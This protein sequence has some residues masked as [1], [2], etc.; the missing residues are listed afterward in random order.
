MLTG[1]PR[2]YT[3]LDFCFTPEYYHSMLVHHVSAHF[4][5]I[6]L[7]KRSH[8]ITW[9]GA[10]RPL[11]DY[12][13]Y[14]VVC[15]AP[16][17]SKLIRISKTPVV[18]ARLKYTHNGLLAWLWTLEPCFHCMEW[19]GSTWLDSFLVPG[20]FAISFSTADITPSTLAGFVADCHSDDTWNCS[21]STWHKHTEY[22]SI[23]IFSIGN[24]VN[25]PL[26]NGWQFLRIWVCA[27]SNNCYLWLVC[28]MSVSRQWQFLWRYCLT[29][30]GLQCFILLF[31]IDSAYLEPQLRWHRK[32]V[33]GA[34]HN[35]WQC[36]TKNG[37]AKPHHEGETW[38][39]SSFIYK[40][41][42]TSKRRDKLKTTKRILFGIII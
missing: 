23:F 8:E 42:L 38:H 15:E 7:P 33:P 12:L 19:L 14:P 9:G 34:S 3:H 40:S 37:H 41:T 27:L 22:P 35:V 18:W 24:I 4:V 2:P 28:R 6:C 36:K 10:P 32:K 5:Y 25:W 20:T 17:L 21:S 16:S 30:A 11:G 29:I 31:R 39:L 26:T 1:F 13:V